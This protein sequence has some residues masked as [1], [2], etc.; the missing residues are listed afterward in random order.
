MIDEPIVDRMNTD[1]LW[2]ST[3][4]LRRLNAQLEKDNKMLKKLVANLRD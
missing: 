4:A 1:Y 2:H 3:V